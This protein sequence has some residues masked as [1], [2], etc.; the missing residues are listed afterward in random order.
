MIQMYNIEMT[1]QK[2]KMITKRYIEESSLNLLI[3]Q[4]T[5]L[6]LF[7]SI[8]QISFSSVKFAITKIIFQMRVVVQSKHKYSSLIFSNMRRCELLI[9]SYH[10]LHTYSMIKSDHSLIFFLQLMNT[11]KED[12]LRR[13]I[14]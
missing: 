3:F 1:D 4:H 12:A 11:R 7:T 6:M 2:F 9:V 10:L 8:R 14:F 13:S 5:D